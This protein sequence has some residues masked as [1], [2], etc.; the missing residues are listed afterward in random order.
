[1]FTLKCGNVTDG[2]EH[3]GTVCSRPFD[4][5]SVVD[6]PLAGFVI[7]IK[8]LQVVVKVNTA[9]TEVTTQKS[10]VSGEDSGDVNAPLPTKRDGQTSLP[11]MEVGND[12][13]VGLAGSEL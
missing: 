5:V 7:N 1:M 9:S 10:R 2:G 6:T 11:F 12:G 4:T 8:V 13:V 3:I